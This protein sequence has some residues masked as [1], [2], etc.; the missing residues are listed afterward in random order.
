MILGYSLLI[1]ALL[2][3][4]AATA[5]F[6]L[7]RKE[8]RASL[9]RP[10][11]WMVAAAAASIVAASG[12]LVYLIGTHQF[13]VAYVAAFSAKRSAPK[14]L[15]AAFWGGQEGSILLWAFFT[16]LLGTLLAWRAGG[17]EA[18]V[19][20][21]V[22][23]VQAFLL[24]LLLVKCPFA[25]GTGPTP[26]DGQGLNPLL[27]NPWM[28]IHPP[29]LFIGFS[30]LVI[31]FAWTLYGL[32]HRD[33]DGWVKGAFPWTLFS[34]ATLG[35]GVALG[36][37]WAYET[38]GWGG[39]WAWDPVENSSLV[40]WLFITGLLHGIAIQRANGGYKVTNLFLGFLPFAF[41]FYGTFLTRTGLLEGFS[42]HTFSSLGK[43]GF[44]LLLGGVLAATFVPLT[45]VI[46]RFK[47]IPKPASYERVV[48]R[49][50]GFFIASTL[51]GIIGLITAVGMSAP[52]ITKLWQEKGAAAQPSFYNQATFPL[53]ILLALGMATTPY[54]AWR[55]TDTDGVLRRLFPAYALSIA[56]TFG[57]LLMGARDPWMLLMF[58][59][60]T[61]AALT[62]VLLLL[63]RLKRRESRRTV[64]GFVAHMGAGLVLMGVACLVA[65][66]RNDQVNLIKDR[67]VETLGYKLTYLGTTSN[68]YDRDNALRIRVE[69]GGRTWEANPHLYIAPLGGQNMLFGNP[70]AIFPNIY[71]VRSLGDL[72]PWNNPYPWGDLYIAHQKGPLSTDENS[73]NA[74]WVAEAM[75]EKTF[76]DYTFKFWG[77]DFDDKT[78]EMMKSGGMDAVNKLDEVRVR[79][80]VD[81]IYKGEKT[82]VAPEIVMTKT[83]MST[84]PVKIP[85]TQNGVLTLDE[86]RFPQAAQLSTTGLPDPSELLRIDISTKPMVGLVW[87]GTLLYTL[88]GLVAWRRR[89]LETGLIGDEQANAP[90]SEPTT[91]KTDR[92]EKR[93]Q[94]RGRPV[95]EPARAAAN[96]PRRSCA[97]VVCTKAPVLW[98]GGFLPTCPDREAGLTGPRKT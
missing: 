35:F 52:L 67:P 49:E 33:W 36:G 53:A 94:R 1:A 30:S 74:G 86:P 56:L 55:A 21:V 88:G 22:G 51:L 57:M 19:W 18:K 68:I 58:A 90:D 46:L 61:F 83:G 78:R 20:P 59:A 31:P 7:S 73:P 16:A 91:D 41:M 34:F 47:A 17:R 12:Y 26:K 79:A 45:L 97:G 29:V 27:E 40:P 25:L 4:V 81:V 72:M 10:A 42:V 64:G 75:N 43:D 89:A 70:P 48:T 44:A 80:L 76:G 9:A 24:V 13:Q 93:R 65:F 62:N 84:V 82:S 69:R 15:F 2:A 66:S 11:R 38:L 98:H 8:S 28:V 3:T 96:P 87:L 71:N 32:L 77:L 95:P 50:F 92:R 14:Y 54:F 60:G 37:Y 63:P 23:V 5:L 6:L 85:G 39:F